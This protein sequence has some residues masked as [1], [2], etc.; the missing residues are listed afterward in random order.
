MNSRKLLVTIASFALLA[1]VPALAKADAVTFALEPSHTMAQGTTVTFT[2]SIVN[3][4]GSTRVFLNA[5][6]ITLSGPSGLTFSDAPF[7]AN[8]PA[9]L[10]PGQ[11][12]LFV[13]LFEVSANLTVPF[14]LYQGSVTLLGG[15]DGNA[16]DELATKNFSVSVVPTPEPAS[17]LL[18]GTGL[19]GALLARRRRRKMVA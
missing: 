10:D 17:M 19:G 14:G 1:V 12:A 15:A 11:S 3:N 18:L 13:G 7:F 2:G 5:I 16:Q 6:S 4:L 8:T 9:F